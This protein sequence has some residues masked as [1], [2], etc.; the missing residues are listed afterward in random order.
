MPASEAPIELDRLYTRIPQNETGDSTTNL[1]ADSP[2]LQPTVSKESPHSIEHH[3]PTPPSS[4]ADGAHRSSENDG[5]ISEVTAD[6][7]TNCHFTT[8]VPWTLRYTSLFAFFM[9]VAGM[10]ATLEVLHHISDKDQ[11]LATSSESLHYIWTYCPTAG[12]LLRR[13]CVTG[14]LTD[15][16]FQSINDSL[17]LLG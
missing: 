14:T 1:F 5:A 10:L 4:P 7:D 3:Q 17:N 6:V 15:Q 9:V 8:F 2:S 13:D 16:V 11:G 12:I